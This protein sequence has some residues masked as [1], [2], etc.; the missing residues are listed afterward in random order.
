[1]PLN[2]T[3]PTKKTQ[4][5]AEPG[6][7]ASRHAD[8]LYTYALIRLNDADEAK[9]LVQETFLAALER[10]EDFQGKSSERTWLT[11]ILKYKVIDVYR[12]KSGLVFVSTESLGEEYFEPDDGQWIQ[13]QVPSAIGIEGHEALENKEIQEAFS[14]CLGKLPP[15][16]SSIFKM[17]YMDDESTEIICS[18]LKISRSNFWV[19]SHRAKVSLRACMQKNWSK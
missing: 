8:Y 10:V 4:H 18:S 5:L 3:E 9:D 19:I 13:N 7:W 11:S 15:L 14:N 6:N 17:K 16:W 2:N 12:K 1:M